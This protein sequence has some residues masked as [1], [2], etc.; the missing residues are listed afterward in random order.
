MGEMA[1][2]YAEQEMEA[3]AKRDQKIQDQEREDREQ[4]QYERGWGDAVD[5]LTDFFLDRAKEAEKMRKRI[6]KRD[7]KLRHD[8]L[9]VAFATVLKHMKKMQEEAH[10]C[11]DD[12]SSGG[13]EG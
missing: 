13:G 11:G 5:E 4:M 1:E 10:G 6:M 7:G 2:Y 12:T 9:M 8:G 3:Q